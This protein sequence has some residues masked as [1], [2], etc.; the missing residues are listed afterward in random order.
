MTYF[1]AYMHEQ[2]VLRYVSVSNFHI[3]LG[4]SWSSLYQEPADQIATN[5]LLHC[6][7]L[8]LHIT[9]QQIM[10]KVADLMKATTTNA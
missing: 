10:Q 3:G 7:I 6:D 5:C 9:T 1:N 2:I 4:N 8:L